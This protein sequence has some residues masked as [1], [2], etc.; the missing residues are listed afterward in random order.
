M[1][2]SNKSASPTLAEKSD[3]FLR[4]WDEDNATDIAVAA[5]YLAKL[6][7]YA[8][9]DARFKHVLQS[10]TVESGG[11]FVH[12]S[13]VLPYEI[14][15]FLPSADYSFELFELKRNGETIIA[16]VDVA[17]LLYP[18]AD[19]DDN[20]K[21]AVNLT[22]FELFRGLSRIMT[23]PPYSLNQRT[24]AWERADNNLLFSAI[25]DAIV[26]G[27]VHA[28]PQCGKFVYSGRKNGMP[29]CKKP[30]YNNYCKRAKRRMMKGASVDDICSQF[31]AIQRNTVE[32]WADVVN[33]GGKLLKKPD[34]R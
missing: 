24:L 16:S 11:E 20:L 6:Y 22:C 29:F 28:C 13:S 21:D 10:L 12:A 15:Y 7:L 14:N 3:Y 8:H 27:Y 9:G 31:P 17:T 1:P 18:G 32:R 2:L 34:E 33:S 26:S 19:I 5:R 25:L 30:H 23:R 4:L